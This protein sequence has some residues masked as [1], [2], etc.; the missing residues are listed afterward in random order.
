MQVHRL[1]TG[2]IKLTIQQTEQLNE[3]GFVWKSSYKCKL[4]AFD[5]DNFYQNYLNY[6]Q[7]T[8]D[9]IIPYDAKIKNYEIGFYARNI[10]TKHIKL[11]KQQKEQLSAQNFLF[12]TA[13]LFANAENDKQALLKRML[14]GDM[15]ARAKVIEKC[16]KLVKFSALKLK[17]LAY[18]KDLLSL[19]DEE[20]IR[21]VDRFPS[22]KNEITFFNCSN[23]VKKY[24]FTKMKTFIKQNNKEQ[25]DSLS[26]PI[27]EDEDGTLE[28][29]IPDKKVNVEQTAVESQATAELIQKFKATLTRSEYATVCLHFGFTKSKEVYTLPEIAEKYNL[30]EEKVEQLYSS[31]LK[32]LEQNMQN[33]ELNIE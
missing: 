18:Y 14:Q 23:Y 9:N 24:I 16:Y 33:A 13:P 8:N 20:L 28:D 26:K 12:D 17:H 4:Q 31:A 32:K 21:A 22:N 1:R 6:K 19:G 10:R 25:T 29:I 5:F 3:I 7:S 30:R 15:T 27:G 2:H 11:S